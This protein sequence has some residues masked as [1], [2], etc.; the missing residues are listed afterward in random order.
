MDRR[1]FLCGLGNAGLAVS[2]SAAGLRLGGRWQ[3]AEPA[4]H[5]V[6]TVRRSAPGLG[7]TVTI[8]VCHAEPATAEQAIAAA[9]QALSEVEDVL[10]LYRP[11]SQINELNSRGVLNDP[12]PYW[13]TVLSAA[14]ELA[15]R[16]QGAFD[17][18]VQPLWA[19]YATAAQQGRL[20]L[21]D[22]LKA[23]L[24][25]VN[26]QHL[27]VTPQRL[28]LTHPN[29]Q[30][31]LN[32]IAQGFATD[33]MLAAVRSA[34]VQHALID[35]GELSSCGEDAQHQPWSTGIQHPRHPESY[36]ALTHLDG[37]CLA[38]SGDYATSFRDDFTAHHILDPR[39]GRSPSELASVS[40]L[41]PQA[42]WAD[43]LSTAIMVLGAERGWELLQQYS[44]VDALLIDKEGRVRATAGFPLTTA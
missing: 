8:E 44:H 23:T 9:F 39:T 10:S 1:R 4:T 22:E 20:P 33:V 14:Q 13:H 17:V 32:G 35:A 18:T 12:H 11:Q 34:G 6:S 38:T 43:G 3:D 26:W 41:A 21:A 42:L 28:A 36:A 37:R 7:T 40:V 19:L 31:T 29:A 25:R 27:Q 15:A 5:P 30:I 16:S 24:D 2:L